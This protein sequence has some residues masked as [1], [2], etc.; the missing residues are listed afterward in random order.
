MIKFNVKEEK[1]VLPKPYI[2][3]GALLDIPSGN[4]AV[5]NKGETFINGGLGP[6]TAIVGSGN[7]FKSTI[8]HYMLLS[9]TS[10]VMEA[11]DTNMVTY[12]TEMNMSLDRLESLASNFD[13]LKGNVI[14][15]EDPIWT[16]VDKQT[17]GNE[18]AVEV[19]KYTDAKLAEKKCRIDFQPFSNP[20]TKKVLNMCIPS[21][22]EIDSLSEL[23]AKSSM[24]MLSKD[25]DSSDTNT[26]AMKQGL[27]KAKFLS[28]V[29]VMATESV[30]YFLCTAQ[31]GEKNEMRSGPAMFSQP[32][33][34]LQFLKQGEHIKG[35][36][37]KFFFLTHVAMYAHT[38]KLLV[39]PTTNL[40]EYPLE[41]EAQKSDLNIVRLTQLRCKN[42]PSG[43]TVSI[44][45]SQSEGVLPSLTEFHYIKEN[46]RFG[47]EGSN[48]S[49]HLDIYPDVNLSRTT[50]RNKLNKDKRLRRAV[51][52]TAE[53][54]QLKIFQAQALKD[55]LC[56]PKELYEDIKK[57]GYDWNILLDTR[58]Y[59]TLDQY[60]NKVP[61]LSTVDLLRMR[62]GLYHPYFLDK[63][64]K[65]L[66]KYKGKE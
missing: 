54:H 10:K 43:Y 24:D 7:N 4:L 12:D 51:N 34:E 46:D 8:L 35:V 6:I 52:I 19:N 66:N 21:F 33:K 53:L 50:V 26:F 59:W 29:P 1:K 58:G 47:L 2:N 38:A 63:D 45:V 39:N 48:V 3:I 60:D 18:F 5:G 61:F 14:T 30:T 27:F 16:I 57:L 36:S 28:T 64:K 25:L 49:Y 41:D 32:A 55:I 9:A 62:K 37:P 23:E 20:Y 11:V 22:I 13:N 42:G 44:I 40:A 65:L 56:S 15:G 17:P 31:L